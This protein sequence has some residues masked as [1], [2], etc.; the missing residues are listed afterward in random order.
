MDR[1]AVES[2]SLQ[3]GPDSTY[4]EPIYSVLSSR[5]ESDYQKS[6]SIADLLGRKNVSCLI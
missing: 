5:G 1:G 3:T 6:V 2:N 4:C